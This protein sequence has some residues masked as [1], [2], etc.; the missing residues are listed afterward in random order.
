MQ[1]HG[2]HKV[3]ILVAKGSF[4]IKVRES[5]W[6]SSI[7]GASPSH[8]CPSICLHSTRSAWPVVHPWAPGKLVN[9]LKLKQTNVIVTRHDLHVT[10]EDCKAQFKLWPNVGSHITSKFIGLLCPWWEL[11]LVVSELSEW[12]ENWAPLLVGLK[13]SDSSN[14]VHGARSSHSGGQENLAWQFECPCHTTGIE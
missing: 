6:L 11:M 7:P 5:I 12:T 9:S 8:L 2:L 10:I 3:K 4:A 13:S 14:L 1:K